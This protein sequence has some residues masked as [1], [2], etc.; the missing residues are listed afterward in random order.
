MSATVT[1]T[2]GPVSTQPQP[3]S[4]AP[5]RALERIA[6][7]VGRIFEEFGVNRGSTRL[8][9]PGEVM[10]WAPR[11]DVTL[12]KGELVVRVDLPGVETE[13]VKVNVTPDAITVHGEHH[14]AQDEERD[15]VYRSERSYGSFYRTIAL[16]P[17]VDTDKATASFNNGV[18][19]VRMPAAPGAQGRPLEIAQEKGASHAG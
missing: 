5:P 6:D 12:H 3:G 16:P 11:V 18:L 1:P 9:T 17:G 14:R 2:K 4:T 13:N 7:E 10:T 15:G 19:E 8:A